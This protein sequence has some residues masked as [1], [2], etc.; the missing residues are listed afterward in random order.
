MKSFSKQDLVV[1]DTT[2]ASYG[3]ARALSNRGRVVVS[4]TRSASEKYDPVFAEY[5][6]RGLENHNAD[7]D[8]NGRVS[9]FEVFQYA[10][11]NVA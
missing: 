1:V 10:R 8:K 11:L 6:V 9:F 2:S 3:F 7:R 5:F 4:A